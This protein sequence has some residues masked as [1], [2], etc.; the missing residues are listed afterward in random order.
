MNTDL[1]LKQ[2]IKHI[3]AAMSALVSDVILMLFTLTV[4]S[5]QRLKKALPGKTTKRVKFNNQIND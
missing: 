2:S 5:N 3:Q 4:R 1:L